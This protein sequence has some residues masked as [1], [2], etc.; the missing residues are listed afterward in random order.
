MF[1]LALCIGLAALDVRLQ[2]CSWRG[3]R[4]LQ[5][6][7]G[8]CLLAVY[9]GGVY[10]ITLGG[11][12]VRQSH[13]AKFELLWSYRKS[14]ARAES[15]LSVTNASLLVE[16]LLNFLLFAPLGVLFAFLL[17]RRLRGLR[18]A[19]LLAA[20]ACFASLAI[21]ELQLVF[22][23]GLFEFDDVL[24]NTIGAVGGY[25]VF[26]VVSAVFSMFGSGKPRAEE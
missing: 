25:L 11:R 18:G 17:P 10:W 20:V 7:V 4:L 14:L 22:R 1:V 5:G 8:I 21:E 2:A 6:L 23:L 13:S 9:V 12:P 24:N 3:A 15:G 26:R 19:V 16:I